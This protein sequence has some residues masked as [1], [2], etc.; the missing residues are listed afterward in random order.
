MHRA[1]FCSFLVL[2]AAAPA[3]AESE[4]RKE[5]RYSVPAAAVR[6]VRI[7]IP[8]GEVRI[9]NGGG[10][11]IDLEGS[12]SQGY[13]WRDEREWAET[14]VAATSIVLEIRGS[15]ALVRRELGPEAEGWRAKKSPA[16]IRAVVRV[17][18]GTNVEISQ[19]IG[20]IDVDGAF[21]DVSVDLRIGELR[22]RTRKANVRQLRAS[23]RIGEVEAHLGDRIIR[24]EGLFA[25]ETLY[26]NET[27]RYFVRLN[28]KI[29]EIDV[30]L[31]DD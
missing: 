3:L 10:S 12:V 11:T 31:I 22:L 2:A 21:G 29:G 9:V 20:E 8:I 23:A 16:S 28:V 26:E 25:G 17:P 5:V 27:G 13:S 4:I 1:V 18:A 19:S 6:E 15:R 24:K 14:I 30:S 7:E